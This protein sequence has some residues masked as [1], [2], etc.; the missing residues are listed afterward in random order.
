VDKFLPQQTSSQPDGKVKCRGCGT[1][2]SVHTM[3]H[4]DPC[5]RAGKHLEAAA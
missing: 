2:V 3:F 1:R 4:C 5:Y